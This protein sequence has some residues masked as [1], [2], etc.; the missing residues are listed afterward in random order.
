MRVG[1]TISPTANDVNVGVK[2]DLARSGPNIDHQP[3]IFKTERFSGDMAGGGEQ[4]ADLKWV[5]DLVQ[6]ARDF[7]RHTQDV[8]WCFWVDVFEGDVVV[9]LEDDA[10]GNFSSNNFFEDRHAGILSLEG[11]KIIQAVWR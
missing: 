1:I 9:V 11:R 5:A 6:A 8:N 4:Q 7:F 3:V 2:D 10:A